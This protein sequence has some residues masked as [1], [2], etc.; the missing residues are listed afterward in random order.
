M[1]RQETIISVFVASPANMAEERAH[2][3]DIV[4]E[5]NITWSSSLGIRLELLKWETHSHAAIGTDAQ[6]VI[7]AQ[8]PSD[9]DIFVGLMGSKFGTPTSRFGSGT[10]EEFE[11]ARQRFE[12]DPGSIEVMFYFKDVPFTPNLADLEEI[13]KVLEFREKIS[14]HGALY[15]TFDSSDSFEKLLRVHLSRKVQSFRKNVSGA[16]PE[17]STP[18]VQIESQEEEEVGFLDAIESVESHLSVMADSTGAIGSAISELGS[19]MHERAAEIEKIPKDQNGNPDRRLAKKITSATALDF[20]RF[21][22]VTDATL[23]LYKNSFS[24]SMSALVR[25]AELSVDFS[26]SDKHEDQKKI[27]A[28]S[29]FQFQIVLEGARSGAAGFRT[30]L[31]GLPRIASDFNSARRK[32]LASVDAV[33]EEFSSNLSFL[34]DIKL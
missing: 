33:I 34:S 10:E 18:L 28:D 24:D 30:S 3:E 23:P 12:S 26:S 20:S 22:E 21:S 19:R 2:L 31:A 9:Y 5:L 1:A 17:K 14:G 27:I 4:S 29:I 13:R 11:R 25:L 16:N 32:A 6:S 8:I 15:F 7:N